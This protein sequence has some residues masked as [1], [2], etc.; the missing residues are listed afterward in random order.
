[1]GASPRGLG[2]SAKTLF[3]GSAATGLASHLSSNPGTQLL[4]RARGSNYPC[5]GVRREYL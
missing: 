3:P 1:M 2:G 4:A 5:Q